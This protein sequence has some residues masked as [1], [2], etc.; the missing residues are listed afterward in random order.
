MDVRFIRAFTAPGKTVLL[1]HRMKPFCLKHRLA[2]HAI[3][4]P[5]V[6]PGKELTLDDL[7]IAVKICSE[8]SI[9]KLSF[10]DVFRMS[11]FKAKPDKLQATIRAFHEYSNVSAWPKFWDKEKQQGTSKGL[12]WILSVITNLICN[13][14]SEED[15]WSLPECQAVWYHTA[16]SISNGNEV[17]VLSHEDEEIIKNFE[18]LTKEA[19]ARP[20]VRKAQNTKP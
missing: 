12:P 17:C 10:M 20:R 4:S 18:T 9:R 13:G 8:G 7:F 11:A 2:L 6:T 3:E 19:K 15:A 1:G 14:W 5:F 16:I